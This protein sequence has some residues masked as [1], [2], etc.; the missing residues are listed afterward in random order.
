MAAAY[1]HTE[2]PTPAACLLLWPQDD[3]LI[4][5]EGLDSLTDDELRSASKARGMKAAFGEGARDYMRRQMQVRRA[6]QFQIERFFAS[7]LAQ[8]SRGCLAQAGLYSDEN[9]P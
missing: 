5:A 9:A 2:V 7:I 4:R 8:T 3:R 6:H 1:R